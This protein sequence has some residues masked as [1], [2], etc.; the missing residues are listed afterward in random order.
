[1]KVANI[2]EEGKIAGPQVRMLRV[3]SRLAG[4][5]ETVVVMPEENSGPFRALC[6][7]FGIAYS[8]LPISRVTKEWRVA[9][10]YLI[11]SPAE[12]L[13]I[14]KLLKAGAFDLVHVS[15]GS[16]QYKGLIAG[17]LAGKKVVWHLND[18]QMPGFVRTLCAFFGRYS[19]GFIFASER[20]REYYGSAQAYGRPVSVIP[21]PVDGSMFDPRISFSGDG[22]LIRS[23][24]GELVI[25][26]VAN[27]SPIKNIE[28]FVRA[29]AELARKGVQARFVVVG[30]VFKNQ[31]KYFSRL[32][33]LAS[34][35][36]VK[37]IDFV[38]TRADVRA[39]LSRFD[40]Y[41]CSSRAESSPMAV[42]EA[43]SMSKPVVSTA[44]GDVPRY[45]KNNESGFVLDVGDEIEMAD[46]LAKLAG[47]QGLRLRLG[48]RARAV[49]LENFSP[50]LVAEQ[51]LEIYQRVLEQT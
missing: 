8:V 19:N 38:G 36:G 49:A 39:L 12:V 25:G 44:V 16:W 26:T 5:V 27:V 17:K 30:P 14:R 46:C 9:L 3:A 18:T 2:I 40:I 51:T 34:E 41:V 6:D 21:A 31:E 13:R 24:A 50:N 29:A 4:D 11:C 22:E 28:L 10:R 7:Q 42:W 47:D 37:R 45:V 43:M 48:S 32:Q 33:A 20:S 35:L 15:G 23:W 1:M